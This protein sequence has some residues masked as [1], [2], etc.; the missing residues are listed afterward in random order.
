M[1][2]WFVRV[3]NLHVLTWIEIVGTSPYTTAQ[4]VLYRVMHTLYIP[5]HKEV[6]PLVSEACD[7]HYEKNGDKFDI[8]RN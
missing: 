2:P 1:K 8:H 7:D 3:G 6:Y 5:K 4:N